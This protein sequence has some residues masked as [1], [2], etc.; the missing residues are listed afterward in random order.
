MIIILFLDDNPEVAATLVADDHLA[1]ELSDC[2][3]LLNGVGYFK[4]GIVVENCP[5]ARQSHVN[6]VWL[7]QDDSCM[8]WLTTYL[9]C[10]QHEFEIRFGKTFMA[11]PHR[12]LLD[13]CNVRFKEWN[14]DMNVTLPRV[15]DEA[16][17]EYAMQVDLE[18]TNRSVP[19]WCQGS[20]TSADLSVFPKSAHLDVEN[21]KVRR[22]I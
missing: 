19:S 5:K 10:I 16:R 15:V 9:D 22:N 14:M 3:K 4:Y 7:L 11:K 18:Y 20:Q 13:V 1:Y 6:F 21:I 12:E 2:V 8:S 17:A